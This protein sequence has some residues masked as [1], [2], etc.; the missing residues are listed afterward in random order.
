MPIV[1]TTLLNSWLIAANQWDAVQTLNE[2]AAIGEPIVSAATPNYNEIIVDPRG[3]IGNYKTIP[4]AIAYVR[5]VTTQAS[6]WTISL[7]PGIYTFDS[8]I[9]AT[10]LTDVIFKGAGRDSTW[11]VASKTWLSTHLASGSIVL[12]NTLFN[13][14]QA[15]RLT[16]KD[17]SISATFND[18]GTLAASQAG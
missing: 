2:G 1:N 14:G 6:P 4:A 8:Q 18:D 11:I 9:D 17:L 5:T 13:V 3:Q 12:A 16:F 10:S 7:P 15:G